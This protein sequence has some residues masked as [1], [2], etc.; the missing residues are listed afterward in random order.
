MPIK[1]IQRSVPA[2]QFYRNTSF[3]AQAASWLTRDGWEVFTPTIDHDMKTDLLVSDGSNYYR[4]QIKT[5]N[6]TEETIQVTNLWRGKNIDYVIYFSTQA[7]WGYIAKAFSSRKKRINHPEHI[8]FHQH[9]K[10]FIKA[11]S[12]MD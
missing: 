1:Q 11:F 7:N 3:E 9:P 5:V 6:T 4:I 2:K 12:Q 8:R 10:H